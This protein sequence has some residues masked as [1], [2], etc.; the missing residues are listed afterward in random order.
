MPNPNITYQGQT[1]VLPGV[2]YADNVSAVPASPS[3]TSVP[4]LFIAA[5]YG[6]KPQTPYSVFDSQS[7]YS[8]LRGSPAASFVQFLYNGS[9]QLNGAQQIIYVNVSPSTQSN[10]VINDSAGDPV[11]DMTSA[12]YGSPSNLLQYSIASGAVAGINL[13][14]YDAYSKQSQ[15]GNN[16]GV[17]FA[18]AYAGT[19]TSGVSYTVQVASGV[20]TNFVVTSPNAGES[21]NL[22]LGP[23]TYPDAQSVLNFLVGTGFYTGYI[24]SE[25]SLPSTSLDAATSVTLP[26]PTIVS[27][28][29]EYSYVD[30]TAVLGDIVYWVNTFSQLATATVASGVT[31]SGSMTFNTVSNVFFTGAT[32]GSPVLSDYETALNNSLTTQVGVVFCDTNLLG[33]PNAADENVVTA[34]AVCYRKFTW[35]HGSTGCTGFKRS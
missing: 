5:G 1:L 34:K 4:L 35:N 14:L 21:F 3:Q 28:L 30:V 16:L 8:L 2:Y 32:N 6:G 31:S 27:G 13:T 17:P 26:P 24:I 23:S 11:V 9:N 18:L 15:V 29:S 33:V 19:A 10:A 12:D 7:L 20:A 22:Q 25:S